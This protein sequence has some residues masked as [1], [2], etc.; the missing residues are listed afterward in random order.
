MEAALVNVVPSGL[1]IPLEV[2]A[3]DMRADLFAG[4]KVFDA[5]SGSPVL[6]ATI[7][8]SHLINGT[9]FANFTPREGKA[10][11]TNAAFYT[12]AALTTPDANYSPSS[13]S[14]V[15]R[16]DRIPSRAT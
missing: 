3:F 13:A 11:I 5:T 12:S 16:L 9:Y 1:P 14:F 10:Y 7:P 2:S 6:V 8:M 15:A 4:L